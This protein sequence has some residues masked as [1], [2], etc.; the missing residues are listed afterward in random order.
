MANVIEEIT[1]LEKRFWAADPKFYQEAMEDNA[2]VV[3]EPAGF[4]PKDKAVEIAGQ[5]SGWT[6]VK[7]TDVK[8][9][10][11]TPDCAAVAYHGEATGADGKAQR[12]SVASTYVRRGGRWRLA[13]TSHQP[14]AK[15]K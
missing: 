13:M 2:V 1:D 4:L 15:E 8:V 5:T 6:H 12:S 14:W 9:V 7:M 10:E 11:L 3:M